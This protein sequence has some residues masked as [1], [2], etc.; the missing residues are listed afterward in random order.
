MKI[1]PAFCVCVTI[2]LL[3]FTRLGAQTLFIDDPMDAFHFQVS[4]VGGGTP[5][6]G[7]PPFDPNGTASGSIDSVF[8]DPGSSL[9]VQLTHTNVPPAAST[10]ESINLDTPY[11]W[12]PL[13]HGG[14]KDL[15]FSV[16]VFTN[17]PGVSLSFLVFQGTHGAGITH[18]LTPLPTGVWTTFSYNNATPNLFSSLNF[19]TGTPLTFGFTL[20]TDNASDPALTNYSV[21]F[22]N[23]KVQVDTVPEPASYALWLGTGAAALLLWRRMRRTC[24]VPAAAGR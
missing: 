3:S 13:V 1:F 11:V 8:G 16:D 17:N 12:D 24:V 4:R 10:E 15:S 20:L 19:T 22:D 9:L 7:F 14:I 21:Y 2:S 23:F 5:P 6:P 18:T